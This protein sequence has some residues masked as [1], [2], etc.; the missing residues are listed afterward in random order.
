MFMEV[1]WGQSSILPTGATLPEE[2]PYNN[3]HDL[4]GVL[5][6]GEDSLTYDIAIRRGIQV[7]TELK[8]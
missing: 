2:L 5:T 6:T 7:A 8:L 3:L 4:I 1:I